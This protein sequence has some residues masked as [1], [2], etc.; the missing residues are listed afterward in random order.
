MGTPDSHGAFRMRLVI[1]FVKDEQAA[2]A[3][4][5]ALIASFVSIVILAAVQGIGTKLNTTFSSVTSA[6]R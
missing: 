3:I 4:E 2:T 6:V 1:K 5:Y